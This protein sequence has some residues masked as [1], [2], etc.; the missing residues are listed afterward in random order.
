MNFPATESAR[1][2]ITVIAVGAVKH[3]LPEIA[4]AFSEQFDCNVEFSFNTAGVTRSK[5][6]A[7]D[8]ADILVTV[9]EDLP[10]M[11]QKAL[12]GADRPVELGVMRMGMAIRTGDKAPDIATPAAFKQALEQARS[13]SYANPASGASTGV[14]F[15]ALLRRLNVDDSLRK[16]SVLTQGGL[17]AIQAVVERK[18]DLGFTLVSEIRGTKGVILAAPLPEEL[19]LVSVYSGAV[20]AGKNSRKV[21]EFM[22]FL[23]GEFAKSRFAAS[24]FQPN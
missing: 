4:R 1:P 23:A 24:G 2:S 6:E 14:H 9:A 20:L 3:T 15:D 22:T 18:S 16:K 8:A 19:Q 11:R 21:A 17:A 10:A 7:G 13:I 12:I 5:V